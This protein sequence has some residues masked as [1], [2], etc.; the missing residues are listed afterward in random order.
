MLLVDRNIVRQDAANFALPKL[1]F[2]KHSVL[3]KATYRA[4]E[5]RSLLLYERY[6]YFL[7]RQ[8]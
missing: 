5:K 7:H 1:R 2:A 3:L 6:V 8:I 4:Q